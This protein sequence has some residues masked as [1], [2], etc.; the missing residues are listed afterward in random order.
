MIQ[1][2]WDERKHQLNI[3]RRG[4]SF[5]I[6]ESMFLGFHVWWRDDRKDYGEHRFITLGEVDGRVLVAVFTIRAIN[7]YRI[8]SLRKA[9]KNEQTTYRA[10]QKRYER[11]N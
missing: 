1:F 2:E 7:V 9:N 8:I 10:L 3:A 11:S 4:L 5:V 6:T